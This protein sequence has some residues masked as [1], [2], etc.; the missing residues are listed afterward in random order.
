MITRWTSIED[1]VGLQAV[2]RLI[3]VRAHEMM[4]TTPESGIEMDGRK[5]AQ[6]VW[7]DF[8]RRKGSSREVE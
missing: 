2:S 7:R 4:Y 3:D 1:K 6:E 5:N 8:K